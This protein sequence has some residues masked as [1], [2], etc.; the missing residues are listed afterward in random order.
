M[1]KQMTFELDDAN[2][3]DKPLED[4]LPESMMIYAEHV[5]LDRALPRIEDGLKPVQRRILYTMHELGMKAGTQYKKSARVVGDCLGKYHPHGDSSVYDAMVRMAQPFNMRM[6]LVD[7]HGN[8][9]TIDGDSAAAM[10]YTEVR[11]EALAGELLRDI[12]KDTVRWNKNFDDTLEEPD[13]LPGRFPNLLVNGAQGIAIGLATNIPPH[14][15]TEVI[16]GCVALIDR[17]TMK[18]TEL[19]SIIKGPDFPTGGFLV[20]GEDVVNAYDKGKGRLLLRGRVDIENDGNRQNIV[21][22]E[23]PFSASK[24]GIVNKI[25]KLREAKKDGFVNITDVVDESDRNGMRV[26]VNLKK[27]ED[28][29]KVLNE[30]YAHT[31]LECGYNVNMIAIAGGK[32]RQMGLIQIIKYYLEFQKSVVY[33]RSQFE[34]AAAKKREHILEGF[35]TVFPDI[36]GVIAIIRAAATR[37]EAKTKLRERYQLSDAQAE[38]VL[39]LQLGNINKLDVNKFNAELAELKKRIETLDKIIGSTRE[40]YAVV[41]RELLEIRDKYPCK[42]L[43]TIIDS[44]EDVDIK[45]FDP[46][47]RTQ[48]RS[49]AVITADGGIKLL[50]TK[51]YVSASREADKCGRNGLARQIVKTEPDETLL[52]F[53]SLGN[54]YKMPI[55]AIRERLWTDAGEA[56]NDIFPAAPPE[57]KAVVMFAVNPEKIGDEEVYLYTKQGMVKKSALKNYLVSKDSY[58]VIS[59]KDGDEVIGG[60]YVKENATVFFVSSDGLAVNTEPYDYPIQGRIAGGVIGMSLNDGE[61]VVYAGQSEVEYGFDS[62]GKPAYM[63]LGEIVLVAANGF[64][65]KV[66]AAEFPPMKRNRKG[67]RII[68]VKAVSSKVIYADKVLDCFFVAAADEDGNVR[69]V[70]TESIRIE[71]KDTK[72]KPVFDNNIK[73]VLSHKE[74]Y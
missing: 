57:E 12:D 71:R 1:P 18:L 51:N 59:L 14:N 6:T 34:I 46:T 52:L 32:P 4:V 10:R 39:S 50:S 61:S 62:D 58:Q 2:I 55:D 16:D 64:G 19:T 54:C 28:A 17:P 22:T 21:I 66:I 44:L 74:E 11:M 8:F 20:G 29:V 23:I 72:G 73:L 15:L 48:K 26:V 3:V 36:D 53:G 7:G 65:K 31:D 38:A 5:I 45:P 9:G 69:A 41:R 27:G 33:R 37:N 43:T 56:L 40:Q 24:S 49:V 67:V 25:Y 60:E 13:V 42:R 70:D 30:L 63:P 35:T 68:D 47:K